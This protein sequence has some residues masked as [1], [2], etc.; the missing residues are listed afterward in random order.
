MAIKR[1][2]HINLLLHNEGQIPGL[3]KNP[4]IIRDERF[5]NLLQSLRDT[6]EMM[7]LREVI[8]FPWE[9]KYVA[10]GGNQ[11]LAGCRDLAWPSVPCKIMEADTPVEKLREIATKDNVYHG[12]W[13]MA[14][15]EAEWNLPDLEKWGMEFPEIQEPEELEDE[16]VAR[17]QMKHQKEI[18][19]KYPEDVYLTTKERLQ[20]YAET[21]ELAVIK[22]LEIAEAAKT[23]EAGESGKE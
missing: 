9:G 8:V 21:P 13:D 14:S 15:L 3:P 10:I 11:R 12:E 2:I 17:Q 19:L 22:L 16:A 20:Q 7:D 6:P 1:N 18:R 4:R 5:Q 23:R